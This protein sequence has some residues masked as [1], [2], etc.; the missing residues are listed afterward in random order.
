MPDDA[1]L[2]VLRSAMQWREQ[3]IPAVLVTVLRTWGSAPRAVGSLMA[4]NAHGDTVGSVSGGCIED[5]LRT[6]L[7]PT[8]GAPAWS[9][10]APER[11]HYGITSEEAHQLGLPCG[12]TLE[13]LLEFNPDAH[14][15]RTLVEAIA[16]GGLMHKRVDLHTGAVHCAT[17]STAI[18]LHCD[19]HS[20]QC[21]LG[22]AWRMLLIGAGDIATYLAAM[23]Q[24]NGFQV[25]VCDPRSGMQARLSAQDIHT[26]GAM[27]DDA[28]HA[29]APDARSCVITLS[30]DP[31]LD[32]VALIEALQSQAFYVGAIGSSTN[33]AKRRARL[34]AFGGL[35]PNAIARLHGPAGLA[36]GSKTPPEIAV[37]IMAQV[38]AVRHHTN[39]AQTAGHCDVVRKAPMPQHAIV[40]SQRSKAVQ[41]PISAPTVTAVAAVVDAFSD[42]CPIPILKARQALQTLSAGQ[43]LRVETSDPASAVDFPRYAQQ[44]GHTLV[45]H[46][47]QAGRYY[48]VLRKRTQRPAC[49]PPHSNQTEPAA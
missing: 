28:V 29:F 46:G 7:L 2:H 34:A 30:H 35:S 38:L 44:S 6:R 27:P 37:S 19:A 12:G 31:K 25:T 33:A 22:P 14:V 4:L 41:P 10:A 36:I 48:F 9:N 18:A 47:L 32:D 17:A 5:A 3:H 11:R 13:L 15:L 16:A 24:F 43:L 26:T 23:A 8:P 39:T 1:E 40:A 20:M 49:A 45:E 21:T 42:E